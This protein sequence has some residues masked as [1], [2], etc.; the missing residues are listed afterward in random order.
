MMR[1]KRNRL[2]IANTFVCV[3]HSL[4]LSL[5]RSHKLTVKNRLVYGEH[6]QNDCIYSQY[7]EKRQ[8]AERT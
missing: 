6:S 1:T 2:T 5:V 4:A 8:Q 7:M 3:A